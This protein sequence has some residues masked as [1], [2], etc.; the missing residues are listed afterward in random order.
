MP[1]SFTDDSIHNDSELLEWLRGR[2]S[3]EDNVSVGYG[4][5]YVHQA[6]LIVN[7]EYVGRRLARADWVS[8]RKGVPG[9]YIVT[10]ELPLLQKC[11]RHQTYVGDHFVAV[12][13]CWLD[14]ELNIVANVSIGNGELIPQRRKNRGHQVEISPSGQVSY[15]G[16]VAMRPIGQWEWSHR[17]FDDFLKME[18]QAVLALIVSLLDPKE[19]KNLTEDHCGFTGGATA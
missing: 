10:V 13:S 14:A 7:Q 17:D 12:Q 19:V 15:P 11:K 9:A 3:C 4:S 2:F 18:F 6:N 16:L 1:F 8:P 5:G